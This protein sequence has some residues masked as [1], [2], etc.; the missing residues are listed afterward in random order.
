MGIDGILTRNRILVGRDE[1]GLP[2]SSE[3][4]VVVSMLSLRVLELRRVGSERIGDSGGGREGVEAGFGLG[5]GFGAALNDFLAL[6]LVVEDV[7]LVEGGRGVDAFLCVPCML[8]GTLVRRSLGFGE[9]CM[10]LRLRLVILFV[11]GGC[12][13]MGIALVRADLRFPSSMKVVGPSAPIF[14]HGGDS[15]FGRRIGLDGVVS[16]TRRRLAGRS[17]SWTSWSSLSTC[18]AGGVAF[19]G[20]SSPFVSGFAGGSPSC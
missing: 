7:V 20:P 18:P 17:S 1:F 14:F 16:R 6:D 4:R 9:V 3:L 10:P 19:P 13:C 2:A 11:L 8:V 12:S 5:D 15:T